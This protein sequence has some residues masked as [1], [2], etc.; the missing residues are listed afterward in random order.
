MVHA[1]GYSQIGLAR[2]N[3]REDHWNEQPEAEQGPVVLRTLRRLA[4]KP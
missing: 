3:P 4:A 1:S 2:K